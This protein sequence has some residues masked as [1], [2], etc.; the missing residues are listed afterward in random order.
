MITVHP[1]AVLLLQKG[2]CLLLFQWP[3]EFVLVISA[4]PA[5]F[6]HTDGALSWF[7]SLIPFA[8]CVCVCVCDHCGRCELMWSHMCVA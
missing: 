3:D 6:V 7:G 2:P 5:C 8:K 1:L 4:V